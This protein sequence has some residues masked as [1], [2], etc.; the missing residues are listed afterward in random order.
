MTRRKTKPAANGRKQYSLH[1]SPELH[2]R[3]ETLRV[4]TN[5]SQK[6]DLSWSQMMERL[7]ERGF[8]FTDGLIG[9]PPGLGRLR[10][11]HV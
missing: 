8:Q 4:A 6:S 7:A 10:V 3:I 2:E 9:C 1:I 5:A 11:R